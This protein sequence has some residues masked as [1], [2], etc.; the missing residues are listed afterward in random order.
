MVPLHRYCCLILA[1]AARPES[2][3]YK[4]GYVF[5]SLL[6]LAFFVV[7]VLI[8]VTRGSARAR[9]SRKKQVTTGAR[10][11][12]DDDV[13]RATSQRRYRHEESEEPESSSTLLWILIA[14]A[15]CVVLLGAVLVIIFVINSRSDSS[16]DVTLGQGSGSKT[17][18]SLGRSDSASGR[19]DS[20]SVD[21]PV[22]LEVP[23]PVLKDLQTEIA[24]SE[25]FSQVQVGGGGRYFI[26]HLKNAG[27]LAVLDVSEAKIVKEIDVPSDVIYACGREK[28]FVIHP[29]QKR[30]EPWKLSAWEREASVPV[31]DGRKVLKALLGSY[32]PGPLLLSTGGDVLLLDGDSLQSIKPV[33]EVL[34]GG[35]GYEIR[36]SA[37]GQTFVGWNSQILSSRYG[38]M[39]LNGR[40]ST[41]LKTAE[42]VSPVGHWAIPSA[43]GRLLLRNSTGAYSDNL[44]PMNTSAFKDTTFMPTQDPRFILG[45]HAQDNDHDQVEICTAADLRSVFTFKDIEKLPPGSTGMHYGLWG[46]REPRVH[47]IPSA[48]L[49]VTLPPSD[50]RIVLRSFDLQAALAQSG[51][52]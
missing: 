11:S 19:S 5:G 30:I 31:P 6:V 49:I 20:V 12:D 35:T 16:F 3:Y 44:Q 9:G 23:A 15:V 34:S 21:R 24:L 4:L 42:E 36:V 48:K 13:P 2:A 38:V 40:K 28:L 18:R 1:E 32:S 51:G 41:L 46:E 25:R 8:A 29:E 50:D 7:L 45:L 39:R 33:G 10:G 47:Y 22:P 43:D 14:G 27:K 52:K 37:D 17:D 26:F